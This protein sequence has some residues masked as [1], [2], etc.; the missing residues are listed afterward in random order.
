MFYFK[1]GDY[2]LVL[3]AGIPNITGRWHDGRIAD[4]GGWLGDNG[5]IYQI[6]AS[7]GYAGSDGWKAQ[8]TIGIDASRIS[9]VY[10]AAHTVQPATIQLISQI[11]I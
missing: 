9:D 8:A 3:P 4:A 1:G 6:S 2:I 7:G 10:G 5:A 11:K